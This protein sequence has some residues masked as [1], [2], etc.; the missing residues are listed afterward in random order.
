VRELFT[1]QRSSRWLNR[2]EL[3]LLF[4]GA[5]FGRPH[6]RPIVSPCIAAPRSLPDPRAPCMR[7]RGVREAS[8]GASRIA[9]PSRFDRSRSWWS[10]DRLAAILWHP[11]SRTRHRLAGS[12][13]TAACAPS[14]ARSRETRLAC[15]TWL[16]KAL[17]RFP[18]KGTPVRR[19]TLDQGAF[20][21]A[22][23]PRCHVPD[24]AV[25]PPSQLAS[26][27]IGTRTRVQRTFSPSEEPSA[28]PVAGRFSSG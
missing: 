27:L 2:K 9:D 7:S 18:V 21:R 10:L 17:R 8:C 6:S 11:Q 16:A 14:F 28:T 26:R 3:A 15:F 25:T 20:C 22:R 13:R 23:T 5:S 4:A 1:A 19:P 24:F 12:S